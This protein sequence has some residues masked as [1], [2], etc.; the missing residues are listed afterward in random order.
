MSSDLGLL[1]IEIVNIVLGTYETINLTDIRYQIRCGKSPKLAFPVI[2][3][4]CWCV[5]CLF[6]H[7]VHT[8][9][10][11]TV[12]PGGRPSFLS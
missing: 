2:T 4:L 1:W 3:T 9:L 6:I 8:T 11:Y 7:T 10:I 5:P 12:R